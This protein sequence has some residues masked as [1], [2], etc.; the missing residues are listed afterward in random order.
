MGQVRLEKVC[1]SID[2]KKLLDGVQMPGTPEV[3]ILLNQGS[4]QN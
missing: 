1:K 3:R 2:L 4:I